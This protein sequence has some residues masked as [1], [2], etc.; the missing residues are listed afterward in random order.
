MA[1][2]MVSQAHGAP[3]ASWPER[4]YESLQQG[5]FGLGFTF[6]KDVADDSRWMFILFAAIAETQTLSFVLNDSTML[7]WGESRLFAPIV[8]SI[9]FL[10]EPFDPE[11]N[12]TGYLIVL[13]LGATFVAAFL[14]LAI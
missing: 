10:G 2:R 8:A 3:R 4:V 7:P 12:P 13:T 11:R 6:S 14:A 1:L 5:L 9:S